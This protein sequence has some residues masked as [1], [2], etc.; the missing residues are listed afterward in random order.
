LFL[1][2]TVNTWQF[3]LADQT[4]DGSKHSGVLCI[5]F[6]KNREIVFNYKWTT[7]TRIGSLTHWI[8]IFLTF[9]LHCISV[10]W[11]VSTCTVKKKK[12]YTWSKRSST[13]QLVMLH[14]LQFK[15]LRKFNLM[16]VFVKYIGQQINVRF[17]FLQFLFLKKNNKNIPRKN[18]PVHLAPFGR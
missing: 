4:I 18:K 9:D 11:N 16:A 13:I 1:N 5:E 3:K 6:C 17:S 15:I 2:S 12:S 8:Y 14:C 10:C 7:D